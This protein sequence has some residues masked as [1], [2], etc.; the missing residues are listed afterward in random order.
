MYKK[1]LLLCTLLLPV[2][3]AAQDEIR[4]AA[5]DTVMRKVLKI[6]RKEFLIWQL[7]EE[8]LFMT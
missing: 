1:I 4:T 5:G 6:E 2:A 7:L 3:A 8:V